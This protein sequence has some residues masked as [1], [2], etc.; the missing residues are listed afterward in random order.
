MCR[1]QAF[2]HVDPTKFDPR[3]FHLKGKRNVRVQQVE[4]KASS[5]N[6]G[7]TL[8]LGVAVSGVACAAADRRWPC[9][10][11]QAMCSFWTWA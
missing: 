11:L 9:F 3:L 8:L 6:Q 4:R 7:T 2:R 10:A 1:L 5:L